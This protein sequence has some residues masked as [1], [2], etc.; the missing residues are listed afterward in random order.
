MIVHFFLFIANALV[1]V[2]VYLVFVSYLILIF[3]ER[4][5][6]HTRVA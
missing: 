5:H 4:A 1:A 6:A 3:K 2:S